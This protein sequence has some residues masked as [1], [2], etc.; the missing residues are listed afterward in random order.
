MPTFNHNCWVYA[1]ERSIDTLHI[2]SI[3]ESGTNS[4]TKEFWDQLDFIP[5]VVFFRVLGNAC[6]PGCIA[7]MED[8]CEE[9]FMVMHKDFEK[10]HMY[11]FESDTDAMKFKLAWGDIP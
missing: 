4:W 11:L 5:T 9:R 7:W 3:S 8:N 6:V 1:T 2:M 10:L